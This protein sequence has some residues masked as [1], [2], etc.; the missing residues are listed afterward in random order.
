MPSLDIG[1]AALLCARKHTQ[2]ELLVRHIREAEPEGAWLS[3]LQD[4]LKELSRKQVQTLLRELRD[5]D[6][7]SVSGLTK[8]GRWHCR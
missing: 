1:I 8:A 5:E 4:V 2:K 6:R 3:D 7:I